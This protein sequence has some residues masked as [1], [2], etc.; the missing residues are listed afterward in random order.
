M[1]NEGPKN[2][3]VCAPAADAPIT[4][5][6]ATTTANLDLSNTIISLP[7]IDAKEFRGDDRQRA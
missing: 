4:I 6:V 5:I 3:R 1:G 7:S 2:S